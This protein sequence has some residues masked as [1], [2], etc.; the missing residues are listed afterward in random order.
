[1]TNMSE[2]LVEHPHHP[3]LFYDPGLVCIRTG[4]TDKDLAH[5][6]MMME[7]TYCIPQTVII[8]GTP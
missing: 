3:G 1:M 4:D 8:G 6:L 7:H 2:H 5:R